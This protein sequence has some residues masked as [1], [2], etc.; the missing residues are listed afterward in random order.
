MLLSILCLVL[1]L[2]YAHFAFDC[3]TSA[4]L[5]AYAFFPLN[6]VTSGLLAH[7]RLPRLT[8]SCCLLTRSVINLK[9]PVMS[10]F[11]SDFVID[12]TVDKIKYSTM[13]LLLA[14][15]FVGSVGHHPS[16]NAKRKFIILL[17]ENLLQILG[18]NFC[19]SRFKPLNFC[20]WS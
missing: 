7:K 15:A 19:I 1:L 10:V 8:L 6:Y 12:I 14:V 2:A 5:L 20:L 4:L 17:L 16:W 11:M 13:T 18:D 3:I 9:I